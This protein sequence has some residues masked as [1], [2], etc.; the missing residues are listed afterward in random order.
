ML[1]KIKNNILYHGIRSILAERNMLYKN[2]N[3]FNFFYSNME[4]FINTSDIE[5]IKSEISENK[6]KGIIEDANRILD[7]EFNIFGLVVNIGSPIN[8][9]M[10]YGSSYIWKKKY[11]KRIK[12]NHKKNIGDINFPWELSRFY[13]IP[14]L[15]QAYFIT[16]D[17][18]Y[19]E[20]FK[21][22]IRN[23]IENN[24][25][26]IGVNW[27]DS[28]S[29]AIRAVNWIIG[30]YFFYKTNKKDNNFWDIFFTNL[31]Y[32][33]LHINENLEAG[34]NGHGYSS[35]LSNLAGLIWL[36]LFFK[37]ENNNLDL[38]LKKVKDLFLKEIH[39]QF[40][41]EGTNFEASISYHRFSLE[42][43]LSTIILMEKNSIEIP[44]YIKLK[45]KK[46]FQ[47]VYNYTKANSLAPQTGDLDGSR[48]HIFSGYFNK[49]R[50]DHSDIIQLASSYFDST[51][52]LMKDYDSLDSL[53]ILK[54]SLR[55]KK[56]LEEETK[57]N[58]Y[59][60]KQM[61][62]YIVKDKNMYMFIRCGNL[63]Q[64]GKGGHAHND[65][66]SFECSIN[67][68]DLI[69]D[70]GS[71]T[72]ATNIND[73]NKFRQTNYHN[74][75]FINN[76]EQNP[77]TNEIYF[78]KEET[79]SNLIE[80]NICKNKVIFKGKHF[81]YKKIF[82]IVHRRSIE[83][84]FEERK[85]VIKDSTDDSDYDVELNLILDNKINSIVKKNI[86]TKMRE[87]LVDNKIKLYSS[88]KIEI[89]NID[90]SNYYGQIKR[91]KKLVV[92]SK[93]EIITIIKF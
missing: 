86:K 50:R 90:I 75:L 1:I 70:P 77:I 53:F 58:I 47:F 76:I 40:Y 52:H 73:R 22:Q 33:A 42:I 63:G 8:W 54:K 2:I 44:N 13:H 83:Y 17:N 72:Y 60:Y 49:D 9:H 55:Y 31:Y 18:R 89:E 39:Y 11:Y 68:K 30:Y 16:N 19:Y 32:K 69:V 65:Q 57:L 37:N 12:I 5:F 26:E 92:R 3:N 20:E 6:K 51:E 15:G 82:N 67:G 29:I 81:G 24:P 46:A 23:W 41:D 59:K 87:V 28:A 85:I 56:L 43:S 93:S 48:F 71:Y 64:N 21:Y 78:L 36:S 79:F 34:S 25:S 88:G 91:S 45:L 74:T 7:H 66:L 38:V 10:D 27:K 62:Y 80:F 14:L 35:Y 4:F 84:F 61:G